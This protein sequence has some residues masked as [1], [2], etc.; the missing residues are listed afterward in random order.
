VA[1]SSTHAR[2]RRFGPIAALI[3]ALA[4]IL[5]AGAAALARGVASSGG[6]SVNPAVLRWA[7]E[8]ISDLYTLDPAQGPDFNAR[9]AVQLIFGG[10][11]RF[12]PHFQILPD[13]AAHWRIQVAVIDW[14]DD[15]PDPENF[16]SQQFQTGSPNNNAGWSDPAF[17][18]LTN[19]ADHLPAGD[20]ARYPLYRQAE[21]LAMSQ[22]AAIPLA[23]PT[24]GIL[25]RGTVRGV[26][27][28]GGYLLVR[29][30]TR[31]T[32][33]SGSGQ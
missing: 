13:A 6:K 32:V 29:D 16:V 25:L 33:A 12:G 2:L 19:R 10:L 17:D 31:V 23:N 8:G 1:I 5:A 27:I 28:D 24:A 22:A 21:Q 14:T 7:N 9:Q 26:T 15:F 3:L 20:P 4:V 18:R 30:W 11:V